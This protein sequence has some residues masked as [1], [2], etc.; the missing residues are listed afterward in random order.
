M[1][2]A[3]INFLLVEAEAFD[4]PTLDKYILFSKELKKSDV[5]KTLRAIKGRRAIEVWKEQ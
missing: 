2:A 5:M 3:C 4:N 1:G